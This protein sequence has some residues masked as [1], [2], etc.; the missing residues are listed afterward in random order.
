M[1]LGCFVLVGSC[2]SRSSSFVV[3]K[4]DHIHNTIGK[5][6]LM[7]LPVCGLLYTGTKKKKKKKKKTAKEVGNESI[8]VCRKMSRKQH[9]DRPALLLCRLILRAESWFWVEALFAQGGNEGLT[10]VHLCPDLSLIGGM[11]FLGFIDREVRGSES[12]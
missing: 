6:D 1:G 9:A 8:F 4:E 3:A 12:N 2:V 10:C 11:V 7:L 5:E